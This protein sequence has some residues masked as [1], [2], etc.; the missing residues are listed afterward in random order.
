MNEELFN[1][2]K[3][4]IMTEIYDWRHYGIANSMCNV[5]SVSKYG[6]E[7]VSWVDKSFIMH[8]DKKYMIFILRWS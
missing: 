4:M 5:V 2:W 8:D 3:T 6:L 7:I 1:S